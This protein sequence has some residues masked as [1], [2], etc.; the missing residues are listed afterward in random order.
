VQ[1]RHRWA[2]ARALPLV[3]HILARL[4]TVLEQ[5]WFL[6]GDAPQALVHRV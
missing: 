3:V 5:V 2:A 6:T 1:G 4:S